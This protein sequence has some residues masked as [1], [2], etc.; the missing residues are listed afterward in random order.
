MNIN[1]DTMPNVGDILVRKMNV[2]SFGLDIH[3]EPC[4]VTFVN[5]KNKYYTVK[6]LDSGI[7]ESF[8]FPNLDVLEDFRLAY[9]K[10]YGKNPVGICVFELGMVFRTIE[11]CASYLSVPSALIIKL[12]NGDITNI[13]G[14]HI[15]DMR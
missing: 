9:K 2:P 13:N 11:E 1:I 10:L 8:K 3:E 14:Y 4:I 6:F 15:Y 12:L 7:Q 5:P